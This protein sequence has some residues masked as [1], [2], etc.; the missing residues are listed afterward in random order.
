MNL[1]DCL[2]RE[3]EEMWRKWD[4]MLG[5][6]HVHAGVTCDLSISFSIYRDFYNAIN[7]I[8]EWRCY[9]TLCYMQW[10]SFVRFYFDIWRDKG[11]WRK[12]NISEM[13]IMKK[14]C[15]RML[16]DIFKVLVFLLYH[17]FA[18]YRCVANMRDEYRKHWKLNVKHDEIFW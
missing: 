1:L 10:R 2:R 7:L 6:C 5:F 12:G 14:I 13:C 8:W 4:E 16:L 15:V 3:I 9:S 17:I 11:M 18:I